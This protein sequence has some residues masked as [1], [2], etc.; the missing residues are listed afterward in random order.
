LASIDRTAYPRFKRAVPTRELAEAFTPTTDE[1]AW[2]RSKTPKP[3]H[4]LALVM[5]LKS[6]QR[7]GYFP[8][9]DEVP[10]AVLEHLRALLNLGADIEVEHD[11]TRTAK[12]HRAL[13]RSYLNVVY[14]PAQAR[15]VAD[16]AIREAVKNRDD[17]A[18]LINVALEELIRERC[19]LP[20]YT[21]LDK[22]TA[23]IRAEHNT[24]LFG[25]VDGRIARQ[26]CAGLTHSCSWSIP[27]RAAAAS[28]GSR[29]RP[30]P[31]RWAS[32]NCAWPTCGNWTRWD[33]PEPGWRAFPQPR[34]RSSPA[35]PESPTWAICATWA[36]RSAGRC[37]PA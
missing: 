16:T 33:R 7:L 15:K 11:S 23:T 37:W 14:E 4:L 8:K 25:T 12:W 3:Q 27:P 26:D 30:R 32:S 17:P 28:T 1:L 10:A 34:S 35:K 2:A 24:A 29:H 13:V 36:R 19:E 18:D 21:T 31:R 6:Y 20:G 5:W 22:L 9:L